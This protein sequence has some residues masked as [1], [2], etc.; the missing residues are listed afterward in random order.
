MKNIGRK[1]YN[2]FLIICTISLFI[3]DFSKK[4]IKTIDE[5]R[6]II[7][8]YIIWKK[9]NID[10]FITNIFSLKDIKVYIQDQK[11]LIEENQKLSREVKNLQEIV[12]TNQLFLE[13]KNKSIYK[14]FE[15]YPVR[16]KYSNKKFYG[17]I[18]NEDNSIEQNDLIINYC[19]I[20]GKISNVGNKMAIV[21]F[22]NHPNFSLPITFESNKN[23]IGLYSFNKNKILE[24]KQE[25]NL[26][27]NDTLIT[28]KYKNKIPEG[29]IVGKITFKENEH[30]IE[31]KSCQNMSF[32][33]VLKSKEKLT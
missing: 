30:I 19:G 13:E 27:E 1:I 7:E 16:I 23:N 21:M 31:N 2:L 10:N 29:I 3:N 28:S 9:I 8:D 18:E 12:F 14:D 25:K 4:N 6:I 33:F 26:S 15:F 24:M 5:K 11:K 32:G 20:I 22:N 17:I